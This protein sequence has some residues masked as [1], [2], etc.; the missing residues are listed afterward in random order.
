[1]E[2]KRGRR[3]NPQA[4]TVQGELSQGRLG[5]DDRIRRQVRGRKVPTIGLLS[6]E[7]VK[8]PWEE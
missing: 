8:G 6:W 7:G 3:G 5:L 2:S 1:M 4:L